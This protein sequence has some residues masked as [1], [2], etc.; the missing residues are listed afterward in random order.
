LEVG[1]KLSLR[2]LLGDIDLHPY[3]DYIGG[4]GGSEAWKNVPTFP[5]EIFL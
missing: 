3:Y 4:D 2:P 1:W 5:I